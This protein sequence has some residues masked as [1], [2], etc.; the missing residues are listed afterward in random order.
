MARSKP[1]GM[2]VF[3]VLGIVLV[4]LVVLVVP[5]VGPNRA[6]LVAALL[7]LHLPLA[8]WMHAKVRNDTLSWLE[9][10]L[11]LSVC[12]LLINLVPAFWHTGLIIGLM[13]SLAPSINANLDSHRYYVL[14]GLVLI[15]GFSASGYIHDVPRWGVT[16]LAVG[17]VLPAVLFYAY[18]QAIRADLIRQRAQSLSTL[19][20][21]AGGVAH[22]FNNLLTGVLGY[23]E[24]ARGELAADHPARESIDEVVRGAERASLLSG[25]LLAFSRHNVEHQDQFDLAGELRIITNL[26]KPTIPKGVTISL[27]TAQALPYVKG[28]RAELQQVFMNVILNAAEACER[29]PAEIKI[30]L[31]PEIS[32]HHGLVVEV[33]GTGAGLGKENIGRIFEPLFATKL[34]ARNIGLTSAKRI[35]EGHGGQIEVA[36]VSGGRAHIRITLPGVPVSAAEYQPRT[37]ADL[38]LGRVLVIEDDP[39]VRKVIAKL[40]DRLGFTAMLAEDGPTGLAL[41]ESNADSVDRVILDLNMP[42]MDGW[43]VLDRI[44]ALYHELPVLIC[45]GYDPDESKLVDRG[46][47]VDYLQKPFTIDKLREALENV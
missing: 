35:V 31:Y 4:A 26:L 29:L 3:R 25:Q 7:L 2:F 21:V 22:D 6:W 43:E 10:L 30:T 47:S 14:M 38:G 12:V 40:L 44:R 27:E 45:S 9:P 39:T 13:V 17:A 20:Q 32:D 18:V 19:N 8:L 33:Q 28:D 42:G 5:D 24:L 41:L 46:R 15:G 16:M 37:D 23:A 1:L 36:G 11:D 34:R